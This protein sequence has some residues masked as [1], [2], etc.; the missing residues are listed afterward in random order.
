MVATGAL[1]LRFG[2]HHEL[3]YELSWSEDGS[4]LTT[5][6]SDGTAKLWHVAGAT[7]GAHAGETLPLPVTST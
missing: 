4:H 2:G 1:L 7:V 3:V 6:S 5:A